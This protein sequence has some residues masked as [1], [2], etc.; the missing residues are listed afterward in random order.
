MKKNIQALEIKP[1]KMNRQIIV[2]ETI[3]FQ[4]KK[5]FLHIEEKPGP[6]DSNS[7]PALLSFHPSHICTNME[8]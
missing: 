2:R 6:W 4:K 7:K 3:Q 8:V 1:T 5:Q